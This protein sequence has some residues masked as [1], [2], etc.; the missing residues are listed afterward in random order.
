M[1]LVVFW[2]NQLLEYLVKTYRDD[3]NKKISGV[4]TVLGRPGRGASQVEKSP[5]LNL[6]TIDSV[7][8]H[9][10]VSRAKD[11]SAPLVVWFSLR[12]LAR[13]QQN[14]IKILWAFLY[15]IL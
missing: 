11:L 8:R 10:D 14:L 13:N 5:H 9:Q 7:L 1:K 12:P 3:S 6:A 2:L 15:Q 4:V